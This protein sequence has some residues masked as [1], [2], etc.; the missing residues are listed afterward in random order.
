MIKLHTAINK[1][2]MSD[3]ALI[4][5]ARCYVL[6]SFTLETK[7]RDSVFRRFNFQINYKIMFLSTYFDKQNMIAVLK[8]RQKENKIFRTFI[9]KR[10]DNIIIKC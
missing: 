1:E 8:Y 6:E 2:K 4:I 3:T 7:K 9:L 10:V 5:S